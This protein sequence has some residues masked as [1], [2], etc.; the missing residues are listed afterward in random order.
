MES[1]GEWMKGEGEEELNMIEVYK[2]RIMKSINYL[3]RGKR[4]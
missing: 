4:G 1:S 2:Y 3:K